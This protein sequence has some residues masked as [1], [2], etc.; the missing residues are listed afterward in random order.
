M[1]RDNDF[2]E[3]MIPKNVVKEHLGG[4]VSGRDVGARN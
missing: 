3:S 4:Q 1:I 2:R